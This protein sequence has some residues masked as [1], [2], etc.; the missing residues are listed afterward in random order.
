MMFVSP[1]VSYNYRTDSFK[2]WHEQYPDLVFI[3]S[4]T[5]VYG[6]TRKEDYQVI[7]FSDNSWN[8]MEEFVAGQFIW[9][10][11]DYLGE[12]AGWPDRGWKHSLLQT[13]GFIEPHAWYIASKYR[14]DPMVKLTVKDSLLADSLNSIQSWQAK[15]I[16][17]PLVDHWTFFNDT[18]GKEVVIFTNCDRVELRVNNTVIQTLQPDSFPDGVVKARLKYEPGE[19]VAHGFYDDE[20]GKTRKVSDT[21]KTAFEA[22]KLAMNPDRQHIRSDG[23]KLVHITTEVLDSTGVLNPHSNHLVNYQLDGPGRIRA[24]D[25][26]DLAS[27][28]NPGS[29]SRQVRKGKQ[30]L[31]LQAGSEPGDLI[32]SASADGLRPSSV[33]IKSKE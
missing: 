23:R 1:V 20:R 22:Y 29:N 3:A 4:E 8:D 26:G 18:T 21:L 28:S 31:I 2:T 17:A 16:E 6:P 15:W 9:A 33:K 7:D 5:K 25:N 11:I 10:G 24:I 13:N 19:L 27:Q 32:I 12:S 14:E 30:L